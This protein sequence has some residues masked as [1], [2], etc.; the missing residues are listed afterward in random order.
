MGAK[1]AARLHRELNRAY[2][3]L[4]L[5]VERIAAQNRWPPYYSRAD[6]EFIRDTLVHW[7]EKDVQTRMLVRRV[8]E[9]IAQWQRADGDLAIQG[10]SRM[11]EQIEPGPALDRVL[12]R[13]LA[14]R[15]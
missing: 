3:A 13:G 9:D 8:I 14:D 12:K 7:R 4:E 15:P 11:A 5:L 6:L 2:T 1:E 10:A